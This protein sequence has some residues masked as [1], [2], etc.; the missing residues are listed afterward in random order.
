MK[1]SKP[2]KEFENSKPNEKR[3]LQLVSCNNYQIENEPYK[4]DLKDPSTNKLWFWYI[5]RK[6]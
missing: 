6:D 1:P 2:K 3:G 5:K 4:V